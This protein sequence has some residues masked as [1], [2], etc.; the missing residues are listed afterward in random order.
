[1]EAL[2]APEIHNLW[3]GAYHTDL[4]EQFFDMFFDWLVTYIPIP[5]T[6]R[7]LDIGCG[8]G[9]HSIRLA[10]HGLRVVAAD[11]STDRVKTASEFIASRGL[12]TSIQVQ[13]EDLAAGLSFPQGSFDVVL[14]WGVLMHIQQNEWAMEEL[15]RVTKP[16]G[17]IIVSE[18][19][20]LSFDCVASLLLGTAKKA[21][22]RGN[23]LS[24]S[25]RPYGI[26]Y[27][28]TSLGGDLLV[29]HSRMGA[30]KRFF[31]KRG[32]SLRS[33]I[34][35]QFTESFTRFEQTAFGPVIH[36]FN[37]AWFKH[38]KLPYLACGNVL[39]FHREQPRAN[40]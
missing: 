8:M 28:T 27:L 11:F 22:R 33:R 23:R 20:L 34:S 26:E 17:N 39:I 9:R 18:A 2:Q 12:Q 14:C 25:W 35:G 3:E 30:L 21:V 31:A 37:S 15:M 40:R 1:M 24:M 7:V 16:G 4:S 5:Q 38:V 32:C 13:Q 36:R 29:R 19:N 10:Q 6:A